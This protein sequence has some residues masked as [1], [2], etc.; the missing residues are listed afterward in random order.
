MKENMKSLISLTAGANSTMTG[1]IYVFAYT[2]QPE[3]CYGMTY[4]GCKAPEEYWYKHFTI[5]G[6]WPQYSAG[7]FPSSCTTEPF[8]PNIPNMIGWDT[9]TTYWPDV[10]YATTDPNYTEFWNHEWTKHGTCSGLSQYDYFTNAINIIKKVG[11]PVDFQNA[12]GSTMSADALRAD[13]GGKDHASLQ[14]TSSK[15]INGVYSCWSQVNGIP[16][17]QITC[18]KDVQAE[19]TCTVTTITVTAFPA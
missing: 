17:S 9:M 6:L 10:K 5:H 12:V 15:F 3:F 11:T 4:P 19:D 8:D 1:D 7:G 2:F 16:Q 13:F 18:P 14:C